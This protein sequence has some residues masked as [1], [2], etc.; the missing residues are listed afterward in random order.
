[1]KKILISLLFVAFAFSGFSQQVVLLTEKTFKEK[2]WNYE[3]NSS[4]KFEGDKPVIVDFYA[5]WCSPCKLVAN[6]L[7]AI[8]K[9]HG[10][11]I[12]VYKV[13]I[14][15]SEKIANLFSV[16]S[17]PTLLFIKAEG[18]LKKIVKYKDKAGLEKLV[19]NYLGL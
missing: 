7:A 2:V 18:N 13:N 6:N 11:N 1:M 19:K 8:Q 17:I 3:K 10:N 4:F 12:Q 16:R 14:D 5:D 9:Q 15:N